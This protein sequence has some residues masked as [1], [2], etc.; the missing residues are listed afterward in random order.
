MDKF[1]YDKAHST[2]MKLVEKFGMTMYL[3]KPGDDKKQTFTGVF[4][5]VAAEDRPESL[6]SSV[7]GKVLTA[8]E[9]KRAISDDGDRVTIN[10]TVYVIE[11]TDAVA[12]AGTP[13][14]YT[15]WLRK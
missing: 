10:K 11:R 3:N 13:V 6:T 4:L 15:F 5:D 2:A 14:L 12:P 7:V 1:D 8:A 9:L